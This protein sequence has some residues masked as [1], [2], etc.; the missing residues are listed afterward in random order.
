MGYYLGSIFKIIFGFKN[1]LSTLPLFFGKPT[2]TRLLL[3]LRKLPIE[4][5]VRSAM[6]IW[7]VKE[8]FIDKFYTRY[9]VPIKNGWTVMDIGAGIGEYCLYAAWEK[10]DV[11]VYGFEPF[12]DSFNLLQRNLEINKIYTV[13]TFQKAVWSET[14]SVNLDLTQG[15]PLQISSQMIENKREEIES[16]VVEAVSLE[17]AMDEAHIDKIDLLKL[18]CEGAEYEILMK[19][20]PGTLAKIERIIMEYHDLSSEYNHL[21]LIEYLQKEGFWVTCYPNIVHQE[22]GYLFAE[23]R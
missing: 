20:S 18:D 9:G 14:G 19:S 7:S 13:V 21:V 17:T 3:K 1:W 6:D 15:E 23:R 10:P 4:I 5:L 12:P 22:I 2:P 11:R 16:L 8:T